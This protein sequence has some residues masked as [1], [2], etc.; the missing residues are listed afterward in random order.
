MKAE[1]KETKEESRKLRE[2]NLALNHQLR[3]VQRRA[4]RIA[5]P[6]TPLPSPPKVSSM[7][8]TAYANLNTPSVKTQHR[9]RM[10]VGDATTVA[11]KE[12]DEE[13]DLEEENEEDVSEDK[14]DV[15]PS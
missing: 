15:S 6:S 11:Y 8:H 10:S 2:Q 7:T 14:K 13:D 4:T 1:M 5:P 3:A 12:T 9:S